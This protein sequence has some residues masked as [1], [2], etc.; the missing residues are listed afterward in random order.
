M[1]R[2]IDADALQELCNKRI[3]DTWNSK[4][5]PVSWAEA[6]AEFKN[7]I[8]SMPTLTPPNDWISVEDR[9]PE[10]P[11]D[12]RG[13]LCRC[14][15]PDNPYAFYAVLSYI[16]IDKDPLN[17]RTRFKHMVADFPAAS[18]KDIL[19]CDCDPDRLKELVEAEQEGRCFITPCKLGTK[20][21]TKNG[22]ETVNCFIIG[23]TRSG[24]I[25]MF[26]PGKA[27]IT[28][29]FDEDFP[30]DDMKS[31]EIWYVRIDEE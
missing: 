1:A 24:E 28:G 27:N 9:L 13:Y 5:A 12:K 15:F 26:G 3:K 2:A 4:T 23:Q 20:I 29:D 14:K 25:R 22:E 19:G 6:Y 31:A 16:H 21:K 8:D 10:L 17:E 18:V 7:D 11:I 30:D